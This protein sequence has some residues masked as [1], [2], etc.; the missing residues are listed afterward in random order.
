MEK[1]NVCIISKNLRK[2][3]LIIGVNHLCRSKQIHDIAILR[4][5]DIAIE[6]NSVIILRFKLSYSTE[7]LHSI[8]KTLEPR[9]N[10]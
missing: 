9:D 7:M 8:L 6:I 10:N 1:G 5:K 2:S 4:L 3:D